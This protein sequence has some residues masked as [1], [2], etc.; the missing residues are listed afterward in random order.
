MIRYLKNLLWHLPNSI[1]WNY[2]YGFPSKKLFL[3]G[4]TGTDGKTT[5]C[6]LL[7]KLLENS[8]LKCGIISTISSPGLHTTSPNPKDIQKIFSE[9]IKAGYTHVVCEVTSHALDQHRYWGCQFQ[10]GILTNISHEHLDYHRS[11]TRYIAT[12]AKL[13][14]QS[15]LAILNRDDPHYQEINKLISSPKVTYSFVKKSD[16][17]A[18]KITFTD[19][20]LNFFVKHH[21]YRTDS[22]YNYQ[23]LNI[24]SALAAFDSLKLDPKIFND[25][26][27]HFPET[28]GRREIVENDSKIRTLIDFA[29]TPNALSETLTS[30]K[31]TTSGRLLVIFGA[32]GGRDKSKRPI[33]GKN[34]SEIADIAFITADDTRN[35][36]VEDINDQIISG[37][38][39][40]KT[41]KFKYFNIPNRQD[42]FNLAVKM[43]KSGDTIVAC[44][45]GHETTI[46]HGTTEY[47]WS[48][49]EAFRSAFRRKTQNV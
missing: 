34:V 27:L 37:I 49:A 22:L 23:V 15:R 19:K 29:H 36:K 24:L 45:K 40:K 4:V 3:I 39:L 8:G 44:G 43:A 12:K 14:N 30:L 21:Q 41:P 26:I 46:L 2:Y 17:Q 7:Q 47:P 28:K 38:D 16:Y 25:T 6:T 13:L 32:T 35:E 48:E 10:I 33:M 42:A 9:Y 11:M 1:F 5:T 20:Y 18:K 31:K